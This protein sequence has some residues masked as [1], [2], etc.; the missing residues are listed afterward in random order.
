SAV[1]KDGDIVLTF[2]NSS[3][4]KA[5]I[6]AGVKIDGS[7]VS[8]GTF[9]AAVTTS[10]SEASASYSIAQS[11]TTP[12]VVDVTVDNSSGSNKFYFNNVRPQ[13]LK[14]LEGKTYIF[15][16]SDKSNIGHRLQFELT[17]G[18]SYT[19]GVVET[20]VLGSDAQTTISVAKDAPSLQSTCEAHGSGMGINHAIEDFIEFVYTSNNSQPLSATVFNPFT[21][22][23]SSELNGLVGLNAVEAKEHDNGA[24]LGELVWTGEAAYNGVTASQITFSTHPNAP[25]F[26][27]DGGSLY[28]GDGYHFEKDTN[29]EKIIKW[30][31][32]VYDGSGN[33]TVSSQSL[34]GPF[35]GVVKVN[36]GASGPQD[37]DD[38][39]AISF[40]EINENIQ[41]IPIA[42]D[43]YQLGEVFGKITSNIDSG[44]F[45]LMNT[46]LFEVSGENIKL[47]DTYYFDPQVGSIT[48]MAGISYTVTS[49][50]E[51]GIISYESSANDVNLIDSVGTL[52]ALSGVKSTPD[53]SIPYY[54]GTPT[55]DR[56]LSSDPN[57]DALFEEWPENSDST[58]V[59]KS[60]ANYT[61]SAAGETIIT[62]SFIPGASAEFVTS[63]N[64]PTPGV[65]TITALT[66]DQENAV[67]QA[68]S[69]W[70][71]VAN[72]K[73]VE[74]PEVDDI[75]G[76][77][78]FGFTNMPN[79]DAAAWA[80][81]PTTAAVGGDIWLKSDLEAYNSD[82][83]TQGTGYG[84]ATLLHEIGHALGL[85]HPFEDPKIATELDNTKYTV[86][87]YTSDNDG[88]TS[89]ASNG[90]DYIISSTPMVYDIA[91]IQHLYGPAINNDNATVYQLDSIAPVSKTIWDSGGV[92]TIDLTSVTTDVILDLRP[93][94]SSTI[95]TDSWTLID[96]IGL[97][98]GT[99]IENVIAG[100]GNDQIQANDLANLFT[101]KTGFG[102]DVIYGFAPDADYLKFMDNLDNPIEQAKIS[103]AQV[104]ND[105]VFS[106]AG[107]NDTVT[108]LDLGSGTLLFAQDD[109]VGISIA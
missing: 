70:E 62:Y 107:S 86:M 5:A 60:N 43:G 79:G 51:I 26:R 27:V 28:L 21:S 98:F 23:N 74:V 35:K 61:Q 71:E 89:N 41:V 38:E 46:Q 102:N 82:Y 6:E 96:N 101:F 2:S 78:R 68:L 12:E 24:Y 77:L 93:G 17:N 56:P 30:T 80:T 13:D 50:S 83:Y 66:Q 22:V 99:E 33:A 54:A 16:Q 64:T 105:L 8:G 32:V 95:K 69:E 19:D 25:Q 97:A 42:F 65:D 73:F 44:S 48:D 15:D 91:A 47:K 75:V 53:T 85:K 72:L 40:T 81:A 31:S 57:I 52:E 14:L 88:A 18:T 10:G 59:W 37:V 106:I 11:F 90:L 45:G 58:Q 39:F 84:F 67:K 103:T 34:A 20:G 100:P 92:D 36:G 9:T 3:I 7:L 104:G 109:A 29:G 108:M 4:D 49:S 55:T 76:T 87:S 94:H 1:F 63:Y